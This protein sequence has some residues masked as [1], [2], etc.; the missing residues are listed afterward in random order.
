MARRTVM[1]SEVIEMRDEAVLAADI[2]RLDDI[3]LVHQDLS[4]I[5]RRVIRCQKAGWDEGV[6]IIIGNLRKKTWPRVLRCLWTNHGEDVD[7]DIYR[8]SVDEVDLFLTLEQS[9]RKGIQFL[10]ECYP[11]LLDEIRE[12]PAWFRSWTFQR[13]A[14][15]W[16]G[17]PTFWHG[18]VPYLPEDRERLLF[19]APDDSGNT[20]LHNLIANAPHGSY[21]HEGRFRSTAEHQ[22]EVILEWLPE[23]VKTMRNLNG[24]TLLDLYVAAIPNHELANECMDMFR[25]RMPKN[26]TLQHA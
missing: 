18:L 2:R 8:E 25:P 24:K 5:A 20:I 10:E 15:T 17:S 9:G 13:D 3:R 16:P 11:H 1:L 7:A 12:V 4:P 26:A 14:C 6:A 19:T 21:L 22:F 23:R